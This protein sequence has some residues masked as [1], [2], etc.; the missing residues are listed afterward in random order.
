MKV[1]SA[2]REFLENQ[3]TCKTLVLSKNHTDREFDL[4]FQVLQTNKTLISFSLVG[5]IDYFLAGKL[6]S[7]LKVNNNLLFFNACGDTSITLSMVYG[8]GYYGGMGDDNAEDCL[9][10]IRHQCIKNKNKC[11]KVAQELL[12]HLLKLPSELIITIIEYL[13]I[14]DLRTLNTLDITTKMNKEVVDVLGIECNSN[15]TV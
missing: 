8:P 7:A 4:L 2:I 1:C 5:K 12:Q 14:F 6:S 10:S 3:D 13:D 15:D 9:G 11:K